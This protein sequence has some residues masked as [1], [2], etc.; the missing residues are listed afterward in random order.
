MNLY[1]FREGSA[2]LLISVPHAGTQVPEEIAQ[3]FTEAG[4]QLADTDWH[5]GRLYDFAGE[6]DASL[7]V[8]TQSR[9][10][11]DLNRRAD[12][13]A[14]YSGAD[15]TEICPLSTFDRLPIYHPGEEPDPRE[16]EARVELFWKPYHRKLAEEIARLH[17]LHGRLL[18]WDGHSIRS[19][20]PR[21]FE[22][23]L[24]DLNL[25]TGGGITADE[26]L[27]EVVGAVAGE[28]E[29]SWV[30]NGRFKGGAIT[31]LYGNPLA[32][33]HSIQLELAQATYM[34]EEAPYAYLEKKAARLQP[35][36]RRMLECALDWLGETEL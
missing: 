22:G 33:V 17:G 34:Q 29:F 20:V 18:V 3:R 30:A 9:Y 6:L 2:P 5:V 36:L 10:V 23:R 26:S 12:G 32:G 8:A 15:N 27:L 11:V 14:L 24:P 13:R 1:D 21:F 16:V 35:V 31:R 25:G 28:S 19:R 4:A 7:L